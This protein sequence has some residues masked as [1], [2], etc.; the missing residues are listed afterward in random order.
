MLE[1]GSFDVYYLNRIL[2]SAQVI[3]RII[4]FII[5]KCFNFRSPG[6]E[7]IVRD[8]KVGVSTFRQWR[9]MVELKIVSEE[10]FKVSSSSMD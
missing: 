5:Y 7:R 8:A 3:Y 4:N 2:H 1:G 9:A 10:A 6:I